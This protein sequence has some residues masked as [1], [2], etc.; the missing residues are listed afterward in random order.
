LRISV[1]AGL[2]RPRISHRT[3]SD[4]RKAMILASPKPGQPTANTIGEEKPMKRR[5]RSFT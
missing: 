1:D 3:D 2:D 5:A 4:G